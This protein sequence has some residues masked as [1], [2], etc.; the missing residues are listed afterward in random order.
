LPAQALFDAYNASPE[1]VMA[2]LEYFLSPVIKGKKILILGDF[3]ELGSY[4]ESFQ[5]RVASQLSESEVSLIWFIGSQADSFAQALKE[6]DCSAE[7]YFSKQFDAGIAAQILSGLD[8]SFSLAFKASRKMQMEK[9][10]EYFKPVELFTW[11][12]Y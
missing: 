6:A 1:S 10:L 2:L 7:L 5:K 12:A 9:V 8:S 11:Q 3:L 4:L